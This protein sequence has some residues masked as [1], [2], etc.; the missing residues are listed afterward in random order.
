[1]TGV[2]VFEGDGV[3]HGD[4]HSG[5]HAWDWRNKVRGDAVRWNEVIDT[6]SRS[7]PTSRIS[8]TSGVNKV[9]AAIVSVAN[10]PTMET[11]ACAREVVEQN[12]IHLCPAIMS[13]VMLRQDITNRMEE[14]L[15]EI[16]RIRMRSY[17][18]QLP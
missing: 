13:K 7:Y 10:H 15:A 2:Q 6:A 1:M 16:R 18:G 12:E 9:I 3:D 4:D 17:G 14:R 5:N 11:L 8:A